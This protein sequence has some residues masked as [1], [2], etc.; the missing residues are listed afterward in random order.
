MLGNA[1]VLLDTFCVIVVCGLTVCLCV[2]VCV[3]LSLFISML[4]SEDAFKRADASVFFL[5]LFDSTFVIAVF[6]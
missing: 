2:C 4:S 3:W 1:L 6:V 5:F